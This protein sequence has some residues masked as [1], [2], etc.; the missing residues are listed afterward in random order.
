MTENKQHDNYRLLN[1]IKTLRMRNSMFIY[2]FVIV[3]ISYVLYC[4][5]ECSS[6][7]LLASRGRK[8]YVNSASRKDALTINP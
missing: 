8:P 3:L 6:Y 2:F 4:I 1:L 5:I 7:I